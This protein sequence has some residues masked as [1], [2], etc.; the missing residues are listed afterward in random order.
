MFKKQYLR[1]AIKIQG[2]CTSPLEFDLLAG[3]FR[4]KLKIHFETPFFAFL[5][6]IQNKT[7][8]KIYLMIICFRLNS[9]KE[10]FISIYRDDR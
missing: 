2:A 8:I 6:K 9:V 4:S 1:V 7:I 5:K 3:F 10:N